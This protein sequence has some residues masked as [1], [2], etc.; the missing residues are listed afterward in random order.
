LWLYCQY[1]VKVKD[2]TGPKDS[3]SQPER[4]AFNLFESAFSP[5]YTLFRSHLRNFKTA[6]NVGAALCNQ[7]N[8]HV[9]K[10]YRPRESSRKNHLTVC[11]SSSV[12]RAI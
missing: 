5:I 7:F 4:K 9:V 8:G 1:H 3:L 10:Q 6:S 11:W 12:P 2:E